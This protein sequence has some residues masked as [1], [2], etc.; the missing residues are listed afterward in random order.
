MQQCTVTGQRILNGLIAQNKP[1]GFYQV[2]QI[3]DCDHYYNSAK[4]LITF[5]DLDST[6]LFD[7][8]Y[9]K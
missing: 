7:Q 8:K 4:E 1:G 9:Y 3:F 6:N 5:I 2:Q